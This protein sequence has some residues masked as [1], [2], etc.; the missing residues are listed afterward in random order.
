VCD[1]DPARLAAAAEEFAI[2]RTHDDAAALFADADLDAVVLAVPNHLHPPLAIAAMEAGKHVLVEKPIAHTSASARE[3]IAAR[4]RTGCVLMVGMNQR[5][6]PA[7]RAVA[8]RI[9]D[10]AIGEVLYAR[11]WWR[12]DRPFGGLWE[13]G[14]WFLVGEQAGGGPLIDLGI[15]KLDLVLYLMGFPQVASVCGACFHGVGSAEAARRGLHYDVEDAGIGIIRFADGKAVFLEASYF[16]NERRPNQQVILYGTRGGLRLGGGA[17]EDLFVMRDGEAS[18][19]P[20]DP[21]ADAPRSAV[22]HFV[23]VLAGR[24]ELS[25][26]AEQGLLGLRIVEAIYRSAETGQTMT[27]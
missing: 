1:S 10:G 13:R 22:E 20:I 23:N 15:H 17:G 9:A 26:T 16:L 3:M 6:H 14:S 19:V 27:F 2:G 4:D 7:H 11:T 21:P 24:E 8:R 25:S 12:L 5:F 18:P